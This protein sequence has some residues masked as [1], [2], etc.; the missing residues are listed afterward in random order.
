MPTAL[1][2]GMGIADDLNLDAISLVSKKSFKKHLR[3]DPLHGNLSYANNIEISS[4]KEDR[5]PWVHCPRLIS[6]VVALLIAWPIL[7]VG[8]EAW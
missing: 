5:N 6:Q 2:T 4:I 7:S 1:S 3:I 8:H